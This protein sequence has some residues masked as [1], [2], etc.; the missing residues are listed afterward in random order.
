[1]NPNY[2][3]SDSSLSGDEVTRERRPVNL[4]EFYKRINTPQRLAH[5]IVKFG[6]QDHIGSEEHEALLYFNPEEIRDEKAMFRPVRRAVLAMLADIPI[7]RRK[8]SLQQVF[9]DKQEQELR[10]FEARQSQSELRKE[11]DKE[12][13][14]SEN[15]IWL[16]AKDLRFNHDE[17]EDSERSFGLFTRTE[18]E[19]EAL[20]E[21]LP[22]PL[23]ALTETLTPKGWSFR[24]KE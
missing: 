18:S 20:T 2:S 21:P 11:R 12:S 3:A 6:L 8:S 23:E 13:D 1:M 24:T 17:S 15:E 7:K 5:M 4:F 16:N 19:R 10:D 9:E 22:K 14:D